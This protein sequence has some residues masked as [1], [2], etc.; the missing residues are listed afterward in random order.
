MLKRSICF[1]LFYV[2]S[3]HASMAAELRAIVDTP[4]IAYGETID[5]RLQY[6]GNDSGSL[7]PDLSVL[8]KD[9]TIYSTSSS[10]NTSIINGV[11]SQKREWLITLL[12][13][14][15]GKL[16]IPSVKA[17][18]YE[19][20][21]IDIEVLSADKV[22]QRQNTE[23][24]AGDVDL[25]IFGVDLQVDNDNPYVEQEITAVLTI[26]DNRNLQLT[27]E[28]LFENADNWVIKSVGRP[29]KRQKDGINTI[30]FFYALSAKKSGMIS[31]PQAVAEGYY[32]TYDNSPQRSIGGGLLQFFDMDMTGLLG[33][34]KPVLIKSKPQNINIKPIPTGLDAESWVPAEA[35]TVTA[36]W[37]DKNP[38]FKVGETVTREVA[39][40]ALG[41]AENQLPQIDFMSDAQWK[42]YPD[43]PQYTSAVHDNRIISQ[44]SIRVVYI[45]QK[46]GKQRIP[47][48]KVPWFNV[49]THKIET[50]TVPSEEVDVEVNNNYEIE[51]N[52]PADVSAVGKNMAAQQHNDAPKQTPQSSGMTN[53]YIIY[54]ASFIAFLSGLLISFLLFGKRGLRVKDETKVDYAQNVKRALKQADYRMVRDYLVKWGQANYPKAD[55]NNLKD[56]DGIINIPEF[57]RQCSVLNAILYGN[58]DD[59]LDEQI[60]MSSLKQKEKGKKKEIKTPL[61]DLYK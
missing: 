54:I 40:T 46:S 4:Q 59:K 29:Q 22:V 23:N 2:I 60:I 42:Q 27:G 9:F 25:P 56:L 28:P 41:I 44:E 21:P 15:E 30:S 17:G 61:P 55:I 53:D 3:V 19:S 5:L 37:I 52:E 35:L 58:S 26:S 47:E 39:V 45:P 18:S 48:I 50:A 20:L 51:K 36:E 16:T 7:Q 10:M 33:V 6:D 8:Q 12:P 32:I 13:K 31:L 1:L 49:K 11:A 38:K 43:K 57:S 24:S 34:Q 14:N